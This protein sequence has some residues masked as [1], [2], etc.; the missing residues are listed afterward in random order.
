[1]EQPLVSFYSA[2]IN[3]LVIVPFNFPFWM[4]FKS[5][6]AAMIIGNPIIMKHAMATP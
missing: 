3:F 4:P 1:L 2:Y 6:L 5:A